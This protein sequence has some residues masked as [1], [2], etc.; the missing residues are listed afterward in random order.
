M[1]TASA[2]ASSRNRARVTLSQAVLR[3]AC[4][5]G[6]IVRRANLMRRDRLAGVDE[7]VARRNHGDARQLRD[8]RRRTP[9]AGEHGDLGRSEASAG[10]QHEAALRAV[11]AAPVNELLG[12]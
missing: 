9:R 7:L 3:Q 8:E 1:A 6:A 12:G 5:D 4:F 2:L 11:A 10:A